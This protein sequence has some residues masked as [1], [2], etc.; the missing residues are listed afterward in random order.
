M[1]PPTVEAVDRQCPSPRRTCREPAYAVASLPAREHVLVHNC[2]AL[3]RSP[4]AAAEGKANLEFAMVESSGVGLATGSIE[5]LARG[6]ALGRYI[7]LERLGAGAMGVVY[8][9]YDPELDRKI[10][11]KLLRPRGQGRSEPPPG[12]PGARGEGDREARRTRTSCAIYDVGVHEGQVFMAMEYLAGGTLRD[13]LAAEERPWREIVR[14]VHRGRHRA[15]PPRTPRASS[16]A[17]SSPTTCCSTRTA[18]PRSSTSGWCG[19]RRRWRCRARGFDRRVATATCRIA[20]RCDRRRSRRSP[21]G[22]SPGT[23]A[24][25]A[26]EQFRGQG[27]DAP[28]GPVRVLRRALRSALR[29]AAVRRRNGLSIWPRP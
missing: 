15:S 18:C 16:T 20:P 14:D 13:W 6:E 28:H 8:A 17:T 22:R 2:H 4:E 3:W 23:P 27:D 21:D 1:R 11:L 7:V 5:A 26:P 9:A 29:R 12:A 19:C 24:Y 10:A 25:M